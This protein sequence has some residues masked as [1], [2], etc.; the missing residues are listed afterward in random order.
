MSMALILP[1]VQP[2]RGF[3][4]IDAWG[5]GGFGAPRIKDGKNYPH[6]GLDC[7]SVPGDTIIFPITARV[8]P[9]HGQAYTDGSCDLRSI[10]LRG[11][12]QHDGLRINLLY[13]KPSV[14]SDS[15]GKVG[16]PLGA[17]Q[18]VAAYHQSHDPKRGPMTNH[19]HMELYILKD[20]VWQLV[21]P[22]PYMALSA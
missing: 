21:D 18:D 4:S 14:L 6:K 22:G 7:I 12:H 13:V 19:T 15:H 16:D 9:P 8:W 2:H 20:G 10:H 17:A 3:R 1:P 11:E 5:G